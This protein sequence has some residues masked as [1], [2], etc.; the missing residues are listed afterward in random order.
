MGLAREARRRII[1]VGFFVEE[2]VEGFPGEF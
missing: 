1:V 2:I